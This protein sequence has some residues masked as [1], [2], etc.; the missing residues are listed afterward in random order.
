VE[1]VAATATPEPEPTVAPTTEVLPEPTEESESGE[2]FVPP[3]E[4][5]TTGDD[6]IPPGFLPTTGETTLTNTDARFLLPLGMFGLVVLAIVG[7]YLRSW[8]RHKK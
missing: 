2:E 7:H 4:M 5:P 3:G 6:F 8:V 1:Q